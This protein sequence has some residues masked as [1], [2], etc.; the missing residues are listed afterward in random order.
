MGTRCMF[1]KA[2]IMPSQLRKIIWEFDVWPN[3]LNTLNIFSVVIFGN[4][5]K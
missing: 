2:L 5:D 4:D 1:A 3:R